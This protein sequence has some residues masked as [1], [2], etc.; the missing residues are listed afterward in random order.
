MVLD[1]DQW[2]YCVIVPNQ[3]G[4]GKLNLYDSKED[5]LKLQYEIG[6]V[7][8]VEVTEVAEVVE[9]SP[10]QFQLRLYPHD[11]QQKITNDD[12]NTPA[13]GDEKSKGKEEGL[14]DSILLCEIRAPKELWQPEQLQSWLHMLKDACKCKHTPSMRGKLGI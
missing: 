8:V 2:F 12:T 6:C 7:K 13:N 9:G 14:D 1:K 11:N 10:H 3:S 4:G 5:E